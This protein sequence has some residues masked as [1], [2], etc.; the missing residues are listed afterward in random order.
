MDAQEAAQFTGPASGV[1]CLFESR[2]D[3]LNA[4][5]IAG[6]CL[7]KRHGSYGSNEE[8]DADLLFEGGDD[9]PRRRL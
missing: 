5:Q 3:G 9:P 8:R 4:R 2:R 6:A 7:G 1:I